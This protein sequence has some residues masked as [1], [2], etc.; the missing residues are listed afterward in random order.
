VL[1]STHYK[2]HFSNAKRNYEY[3]YQQHIPTHEK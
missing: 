2:M 1:V 3:V